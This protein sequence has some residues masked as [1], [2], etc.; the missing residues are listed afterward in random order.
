MNFNRPYTKKALTFSKTH[1]ILLD[2]IEL[3]IS[4]ERWKPLF[5]FFQP[6]LKTQVNT[7][8][9]T[10]ST[11]TI[12]IGINSTD[13]FLCQKYV[14]SVNLN[15]CNL[16]FLIITKGNDYQIIGE[17]G[18][19]MVK[20]LKSPI[21]SEFCIASNKKT[22]NFSIVK[23]ADGDLPDSN[24]II[25]ILHPLQYIHDAEVVHHVNTFIAEAY[26]LYKVSK[27]LGFP[28]DL[29]NLFYLYYR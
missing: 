24:K 4:V 6:K 5:S 15:L 1:Y 29:Q 22:V 20:N 21:T 25:L 11:N 19:L 17:A 16:V 12:T 2:S 9:N 14:N 7:S 26:D 8:T 3:Y 18:K 13:I 27:Q 23:I 10:Y 28:S